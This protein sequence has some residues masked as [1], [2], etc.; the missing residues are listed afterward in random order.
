MDSEV[1][2]SVFNPDKGLC[3]VYICLPVESA[4]GSFQPAYDDK[5]MQA[6]NGPIAVPVDEWCAGGV[7]NILKD[8]W[9]SDSKDDT[10]FYER[11]Y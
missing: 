10:Y 4:S 11:N 1:L 5:T 7:F 3:F 9:I 6:A 8:F 2:D